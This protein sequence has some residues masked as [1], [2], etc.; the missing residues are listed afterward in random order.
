VRQAAVTMST[1]QRYIDRLHLPWRA[2]TRER[3]SD[4]PAQNRVEIVSVNDGAWLITEPAEWG[5]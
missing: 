2:V 1:G 3:R 4:M 5:E